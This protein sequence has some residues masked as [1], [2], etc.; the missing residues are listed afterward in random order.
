[1]LFRSIEQASAENR[2][3]FGESLDHDFEQAAG[4]LPELL[5]E[6]DQTLA[7]HSKTLAADLS[8]HQQSLARTRENIEQQGREAANHLR[9]QREQGAQAVQVAL[10]AALAAVEDRQTAAC[11]AV[12][13][14]LKEIQQQREAAARQHSTQEQTVQKWRAGLETEFATLSA[15]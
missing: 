3:R 9:E 1:M 14:Q 4:R 8:G 5:R 15:K 12:S 13:E 11:T 2:K 7:E 6:L 10:T